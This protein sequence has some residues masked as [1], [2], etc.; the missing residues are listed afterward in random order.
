MS[1]TEERSARL[2]SEFGPLRIRV[3]Q[4]VEEALETLP[5]I[6]GLPSARLDELR[7]ALFHTDHPYLLV[8]V[9]PFSSGKSSLIN[10]LLRHD[11]ADLEMTEGPLAIG[12]VP[13]T[14]RIAILRWGS[15][16]ERRR[17]GESLDGVY[18]P[19]PI[20]RRI[21]FVDTPGL[22]SVFQAQ[23]KIT[24]RFLHRSDIVFW[25]MSARQALTAENLD[26]LRA[27]KEFGKKTILLLNQADTLAETERKTVLAFVQEQSQNRLGWQPRVWLVSAKEGL[28]AQGEKAEQRWQESGLAEVMDYLEKQLGDQARLQQKLS[29]PLQIVQRATTDAQ[30]TLAE[31]QVHWDELG[32]AMANLGGQVAASR[33][34]GDLA[35]EGARQN[36]ATT[37]RMVQDTVATGWQ[38]SFAWRKIPR[39]MARGLLEL[40]GL[41]WL[42]H[43]GKSRRN[44]LPPDLLQATD[45]WQDAAEKL[46]SRLEARDWQDSGDLVTAA[47]SAIAQLPEAA[48]S[49]LVGNVAAPS[50]YDRSALEETRLALRHLADE[51]RRQEEKRQA[52]SAQ[53]LLN[54]VSALQ[55]TV[56]LL[57]LATFV[58]RALLADW[59]PEAPLYALL[60]LVGLFLASAFWLPISARWHVARFARRW[61]QKEERALEIL[62]EGAERQLEYGLQLRQDVLLPLTRL[63]QAH[64]T[65]QQELR[66]SL[67]QISSQISE[68]E[69]AIHNLGRVSWGERLGLRRSQPDAEPGAETA[70]ADPP[71]DEITAPETTRSS[72]SANEQ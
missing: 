52:A 46:A 3:R 54:G 16:D 59:R 42:A 13:T 9:G 23:E 36:L 25:V 47:Q 22:G 51:E 17:E 56:I 24:Q 5:Q 72:E 14:D 38:T 70:T 21:S 60:V 34:Q 58:G 55:V 48:R 31:N 57:A 20:L 61:R 41:G 6:E 32:R 62:N 8:F 2:I 63:W 44:L 7:D 49:R 37:S 64:S 30:T 19:A 66:A 35:L 39:L 67:H 27:L 28:A 18:F 53:W 26:D 43:R 33:A 65:S 45:G 10:A 15:E 29:T 12:P 69:G 11:V 71:A 50:R 1:S 68:L 4:L 40:L